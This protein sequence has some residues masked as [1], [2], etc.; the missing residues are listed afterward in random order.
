MIITDKV[1]NFLGQLCPLFY[2]LEDQ[3]NSAERAE[4]K[5][6]EIIALM[7]SFAH[8]CVFQ[9]A[10]VRR[11]GF[12]RWF[13]DSERA[14]RFKEAELTE[15]TPP[16]RPYDL[17]VSYPGPICDSQ[18]KYA[19]GLLVWIE[20]E[21]IVSPVVG[22]EKDFVLLADG[23]LG[24]TEYTHFRLEGV[25]DVAGESV[26]DPFEKLNVISR[27]FSRICK[28]LEKWTFRCVHETFP[29]RE[30]R[31]VRFW[32]PLALIKGIP[33][34]EITGEGVMLTHSLPFR[35]QLREEVK[36]V[37]WSVYS[38]AISAWPLSEN[39]VGAS[40]SISP[41]WE[42][43]LKEMVSKG[44]IVGIHMIIAPANTRI[45]Q[46]SITNRDLLIRVRVEPIE[47]ILD[48]YDHEKNV[49]SGVLTAE[50]AG[51]V[52]KEVEAGF[53]GFRQIEGNFLR[54]CF[55]CNHMAIAKFNWRAIASCSCHDDYM[56]HIH[57]DRPGYVA[58]RAFCRDHE[59]RVKADIE[60]LP[61]A[62]REDSK[63]GRLSEPERSNTF[64]GGK[65]PLPKNSTVLA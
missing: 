59:E 28:P 41:D 65:F 44:K 36:E 55:Y 33:E 47:F 20:S 25:Y 30:G 7:R 21:K 51:L 17:A 18:A 40:A 38:K 11:D 35:H 14:W 57:W 34:I 27:G 63:E 60:A 54:Q 1:K 43:R 4:E 29:G 61:M 32:E 13:A 9:R 39:F 52:R 58:E 6:M 50:K 53:Q 16:T 62:S 49:V 37:G 12:H 56:G 26:Y 22:T 19:S 23:K 42:A 8:E 45:D 5:R 2:G 3:R 24:I 31:G 48:S 10:S 64:L 46:V 15:T